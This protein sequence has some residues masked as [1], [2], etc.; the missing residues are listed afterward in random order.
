MQKNQKHGFT[1]VELL[2]TI[3]IIGILATVTVVSVGS[4]RAKARDAKRVSEVRAIQTALAVYEN[5]KSKFPDSGAAILILGSTQGSYSVLCDTDAG[6]QTDKTGCAA[7][8]MERVPGDPLSKPGSAY[9][10]KY[11]S[12]DDKQSYTIF[13]KLETKFG[14]LDAGDH[15]ATP[16]GAQ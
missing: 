15:T 13:F 10:Y 2:V 4:A 1:L 3:G 12:S 11:S 14:S 5:E 9:E 16:A 8:F 6:F 7:Y